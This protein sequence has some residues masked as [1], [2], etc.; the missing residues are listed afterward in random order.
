MRM[1][2][3]A[4]L[5]TT[6]SSVAAQVPGMFP[7]WEAPLRNDLGLTDD[8]SKQ[9][10]ATLS[11]MRPKMI[12]LRGAVE[13]AESELKQEMD[14]AQVDPRKVNDAIEKVVTARAELTRAVAQMSLKL[15]LVLT[16]AQWQEL[17]KRQ[18]R[19]GGRHMNPRNPG[20]GGP[21]RHPPGPDALK[22][23]GPNN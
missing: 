16:P 3:I 17:Q 7:W 21:L 13:S 12:E 11:D 22:P 5:C 14:A 2:Q 18:P 8:Q 19:M 23:D 6:V 9:I 4:L 10:R 20:T 15:R 1:L